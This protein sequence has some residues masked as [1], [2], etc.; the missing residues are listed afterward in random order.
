M[1]L[2]DMANK[3]HAVEQQQQSSKEQQPVSQQQTIKTF[4]RRGATSGK[5]RCMRAGVFE[6]LRYACMLTNRSSALTN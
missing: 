2:K 4:Q 3:A 1:V 6:S 5:V